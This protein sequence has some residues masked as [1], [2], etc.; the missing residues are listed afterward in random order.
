MWVWMEIA[1]FATEKSLKKQRKYSPGNRRKSQQR[2]EDSNINK[3]ILK[4]GRNMNFSKL[5]GIAI[6]TSK[7]ISIKLSV[8]VHNQMFSPMK[9]KL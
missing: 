8:Q 3:P 9:T 1:L 4:R 5:K 2:G 7:M 6:I